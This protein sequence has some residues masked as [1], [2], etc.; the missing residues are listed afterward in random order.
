MIETMATYPGKNAN[1]NSTIFSIGELKIIDKL[2]EKWFI[3]YAGDEITID[4][5][6]KY[7]FFLARPAFELEELLGINREVIF[8]ISTYGNFEVRTLKVFNEIE[9]HFQRKRIDTTLR[10]IISHDKNCEEKIDR[11][12]KQD[13]EEPTIIP[14]IYDEKNTQDINEKIW[15]DIQKN[16]RLRDLF[17]Y[18]APLNSELLFFGRQSI[19]H[20]LVTKFE[21]GKLGGLFG[22]RRSGK[23]SVIHGIRRS[24]KTK[25]Y[26]FIALDCQDTSFYN[27]TWN[28]AIAF[29]C[30]KIRQAMN[31]SLKDFS[32]EEFTE[33]NA[34]ILFNENIEKAY[35]HG[36]SKKIFLVFD[37]IERISPK[38]AD[39]ESWRNGHDF[40]HFWRCLRSKIQEVGNKRVGILVVG[41][42]PVIFEEEKFNGLDNPLYGGGFIAY[43]DPF[44]FSQTKDMISF[45]GKLSGLIFDED[46]ISHIHIDSGGIPF[47]SRQ[48]CSEIQNREGRIRPC[49]IRLPDYE[50]AKKN[51]LHRR[52]TIVDLLIGSIRDLYPDEYEMLKYLAAGDLK[53]FEYYVNNQ[54]SFVSHL[55]GYGVIQESQ[56]KY[57]F[58]IP[59]VKKYLLDKGIARSLNLSQEERRS[60]INK[61]RNSLEIAL[62]KMIAASF[63]IFFGNKGNE[64]II[65]SIGE[66]RR[67]NISGDPISDMKK[68]ESAGLFFMELYNI[69]NNNWDPIKNLLRNDKESVLYKIK[70][71]NKY[72][73]DAHADPI[74]DSEFQG[75]RTYFSWFEENLEM[76]YEMKRD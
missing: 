45:I 1:F 13:P 40:I 61:R 76:W 44:N 34:S 21:D 10:F 60:E 71:I 41:T 49:S 55:I 37:E 27:V 28:K 15:K 63:E 73:K 46:I 16:F 24:L 69:I 30:L 5:N 56:N 50:D 8:A 47:F 62:R 42:S 36:G 31:I 75:I 12:I 18:Q 74:S 19:I 4:Y 70:E 32:I 38:T 57:S 29:L 64:K 20:D 54:P 68:G 72:R 3:T 33:D 25:P 67:C 7:R 14:I 26:H 2:S 59:D 17:G 53:E 52:N 11:I 22:V 35:V 43:L 23:T 9:S 58:R 48:I 66:K 65:T 39:R 6:S 51:F